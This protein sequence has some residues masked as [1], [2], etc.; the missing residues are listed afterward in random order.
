MQ[1]PSLSTIWLAFGGATQPI[2]NKE[3]FNFLAKSFATPSL[4]TF[5]LFVHFSLSSSLVLKNFF[6]FFPFLKNF[7]KG[8][9]F[10]PL[11]FHSNKVLWD[12][13]VVSFSFLKEFF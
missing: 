1:S 3:S 11:I 5:Y 12:F 6:L 9:F 7:F 13:G 8:F 4:T 10:F 2:L